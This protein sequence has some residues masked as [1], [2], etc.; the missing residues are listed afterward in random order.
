[1]PSIALYLKTHQPFRVKRYRFFDIGKDHNYFN[2]SHP[3]NK[4]NN[5]FIIKKV[6]AKSY[7]PANKKLLLLLERYPDFKF[8]ISLSGVL[9]EQLERVSPETIESFRKLIDT[10][11]VEVLGE[12]YYHSLSFFYSREEFERQVKMQEAILKRLFNV[13]KPK[14]F[15]NTELAYRNDLGEWIDQSDY[16]GVVTEGW[17][18][19]LGWR[20]PNYVYKPKGAKRSHLLLKNYKLSDDVAFRFSNKGW[21]EWPLTAEKYSHWLHSISGS[22]D[23]VNLFM[24]Y[25]TFGEHQ[26]EETGIFDFLEA[27]PEYVYKHPD[28]SFKTV[29]ETIQSYPV[30]DEV[31]VSRILTWADTERDLTAWTGNEMQRSVLDILYGMK[32]KVIAYGDEKLIDDW[33]KLQTSDHVYYMCTKWFS[34]GDV[35]AYFSPYESPYEA[36]ISVMNAIHDLQMRLD[37]LVCQKQ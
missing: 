21:S 25:E 15:S 30:R 5:D 37:D 33:R 7:L 1:M 8:S 23:T 34:D 26:W 29:S 24:D 17:D 20:S 12:T 9:L 32:D 16:H 3:T 2:D 6:A 31:D 13:D 22:G 19:I 28:W 18:P 36:Y 10:G 14:V 27:L 4:T 11:R 35:H